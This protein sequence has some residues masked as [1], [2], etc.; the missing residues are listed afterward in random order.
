MSR[1]RLGTGERAGYSGAEGRCL[2]RDAFG[3]AW[4]NRGETEGVAC[5]A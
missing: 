2:P 3:F 1:G 5:P 4:R